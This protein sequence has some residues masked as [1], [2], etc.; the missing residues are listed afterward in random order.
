MRLW[1]QEHKKLWRSRLTRT[2]VCGMFLLTL[3]LQIWA[4]QSANFGTMRA[5]ESRQADG[6]AN[7]RKCQQYAA[8]WEMLTDATTQSMV[9]AYQQLLTD[10]SNFD[11]FLA[12]FSF[13]QGTLVSFLWPEVEDQTQAYP[14]L[15]IYYVDPARLT[16]LYERREEKIE[17]YLENQFSDPEDRQ[18]FLDMDSRVDKPMAYGWAAGW[19][20]LL[21]N[22]IG[23][24][25]QMILPVVLALAL[26]SVFAGEYRRG[27]D[28]LQ[29]T[30]LHGQSKLAVAKL[31]SGGA[32][33]VEVFVIFAAT[34]MAVQ[35]IWLGF[36]G[37][38]LPI[39]LIKMLATAPMNMWQ[40]ECYEFAYIFC[41]ALGFAGMV[42]LASACLRNSTL[43][44]VVALMG[45]WL[46]QVLNHYLPWTVQQYMRLLPF[47]GGAEDIFRQN[48]YHW[49]GFRIWSPGPLLV[50][51]LM[52]GGICLPFT[53]KFW[54]SRKR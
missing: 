36:E 5:D 8:Q 18:F 52:L 38:D 49:V 32:F 33:S 41:S 30:S 14:T 3:G 13:L 44:I 7:I 6:Y 48:L 54:C 34:M 10:D 40:A 31:L 46:P 12:N 37:W 39:Q 9:N 53:I 17:Y 24:F 45:V 21:G 19:S 2:A 51:P 27:V 26:A 29:M 15:T 11:G 43:A 50:I 23:A 42:L 4:M 47:V 20:S 16:N 28:A 1:W 22:G 25:G 35:A